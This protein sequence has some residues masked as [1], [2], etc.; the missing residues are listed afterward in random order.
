MNDIQSQ[1]TCSRCGR[2]LGTAP[3]PLCDN[4]RGFDHAAHNSFGMLGS[5][6]EAVDG[7]WR[8]A[9]IVDGGF[10]DWLCPHVHDSPEAAEA[11]PELASVLSGPPSRSSR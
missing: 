11:C 8:V 2:S 9:W 6:L 3:A 5:K 10:E 7:G 4:C 1:P